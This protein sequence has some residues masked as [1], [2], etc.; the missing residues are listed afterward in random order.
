MTPYGNAEPGDYPALFTG[1]FEAQY[2]KAI[3]LIVGFVILN[4]DRATPHDGA[5]G[6]GLYAVAVCNRSEGTNPKSKPFLIRKAMLQPEEFADLRLSVNP[7]PPEHFETPYGDRQRVLDIRV[8]CRHTDGRRVSLVTDICR[9]RDGVWQGI[10]GVYEG[11]QPGTRNGRPFWLQEDGRAIP[12]DDRR[13]AREIEAGRLT[14]EAA[15]DW[16]MWERTSRNYY[17]RWLNPDGT[18]QVLSDADRAAL[19]IDASLRYRIAQQRAA[20]GCL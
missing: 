11:G 19:G 1:C 6:G 7:P 2:P 15:F 14:R 20:I 9:P 5:D 3:R 12:F 17:A 8:V 18:L 13:A 4:P 10:E 16:Q